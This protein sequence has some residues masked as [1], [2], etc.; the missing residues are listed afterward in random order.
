MIYL[1]V[2]FVEMQM[3]SVLL[4]TIFKRN[5]IQEVFFLLKTQERKN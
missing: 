1:K 2:K 4:Y 5:F 3:F